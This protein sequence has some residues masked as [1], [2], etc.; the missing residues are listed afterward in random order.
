MVT[1]V[2]ISP[3]SRPVTGPSVR[4]EWRGH[5]RATAR[6]APVRGRR[7]LPKYR[8]AEHWRERG[9]E[10]AGRL[11]IEHAQGHADLRGDGALARGAGKAGIAAVEFQ[12][13]G[14]AQVALGDSAIS[15]ARS[16]TARENKGRIASMVSTRRCG[17]ELRRNASS[18]GATFARNATW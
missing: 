11:H 3:I 13:A 10:R 18:Q 6:L 5:R 16:S 8:V 14:A 4:P 7:L 17:A 2:I 15:T 9:F 1:P 12:P